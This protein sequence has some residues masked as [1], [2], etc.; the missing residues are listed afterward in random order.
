MN[1]V[2]AFLAL[3]LAALLLLA[4]G[5]ARGDAVRPAAVAGS[6][7]PGDAKTLSRYIDRLLAE[8]QPSPE[9]RQGPPVRALI[10][11]HAGYAYSGA[12]AAA[13]YKLVEGHSYRRVVVLGPAHRGGFRGLSIAKVEAYETPLGRIPLD[14][15][16]IQRLRASPLVTADAQAH[17]REHSIEMQLPFL[18][19]ALTPGWKLVP[20][21]VGWME[22]GDR[23]R[24]AELLR[25]LLDDQTLLVVSTDFTHYGPNY[26]YLPFPLDRHTPQRIKRLDQG[27]VERILAGDAEGFLAYRRRTGITIC[28]REA[29]A[30]LLHL[31]PPGVHARVAAH[32][33]SGALTGD[34]RNSVS[35]W[36]I[37]FR[38]QGPL[39]ADPPA[40][41][42]LTD[43]E[44]KLLE[45][46]AILGV[47]DAVAG[48]DRNDPSPEYAKLVKRLPARLK[49]PAGA[50]V[51][52]WKE[53]RLRGCLG[54]IPPVLPLYQAV[55]DN[56]WS[57]ARDDPRFLPV[58]PEELPRLDLEISVLS[59]PV[60][61]DSPEQFQ[62]G[63]QGIVLNKD[64][65]RAVFLPE[66]AER[67]GWSREETLS[68]LALK[69]GL[70]ADAW[71]AEDTRL[72]VFITSEHRFS[73]PF[74]DTPR[75]MPTTKEK[76]SILDVFNGSNE[77]Q[78][79]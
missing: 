42:P 69:A 12:T 60:P 15:E 67:F 26:R 57:A 44:W 58:T 40:D 59:P 11:P 50:F 6:W 10:V 66:V 38:S 27:A 20:V 9:S 4:G 23:R 18:Q 72:E 25:P 14:I 68:R 41:P 65:R 28:G 17:E 52:L 47:R 55:Y 78:H 32:T 71:K 45:Q 16:A 22:A 46:I 19:R 30:I 35:Y 62:V 49:R 34:Y 61:I 24:A 76:P 36:A 43:Q 63:R 8:A 3:L 1:R 29:V 51:T 56:A 5:L 75:G 33:T 48:R 53:D 77:K 2:R 74:S 70:P 79:E 73:A 21:L 54:Y 13:G 64:G 37:V 31:L 39:N 7:Y